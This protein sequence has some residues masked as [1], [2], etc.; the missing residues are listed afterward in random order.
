VQGS[1][2]VPPIYGCRPLSH[3]FASPSTNHAPPCPADPQLP[4][5]LPLISCVSHPRAS[6][7]QP[8]RSRSV[9]AAAHHP[10]MHAAKQPQT[11]LPRPCSPR[12]SKT[13]APLDHPNLPFRKTP[14][15][16]RAS[17]GVPSWW[18]RPRQPQEL[19][20]R[21]DSEGLKELQS[22]GDGDRDGS[23]GD[24]GF[25]HGCGCGLP[26]SGQPRAPGRL[27]SSD[28]GAN[29]FSATIFVGR[30]RGEP[31][32]PSSPR[33]MSFVVFFGVGRV[34]GSPLPPP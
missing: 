6:S 24:D 9:S 2:P 20:G 3:R 5:P 10:P 17:T 11:R 31:V 1:G 32:V 16:N 22:S 8:P 34:R 13:R 30:S 23:G 27:N 28:D 29:P 15:G 18:L 19:S 14:R 33:I 7:Q 12:H 26:T 21:D 25:R 4:P